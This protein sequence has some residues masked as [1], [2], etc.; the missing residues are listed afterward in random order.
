MDKGMTMAKQMLDLQRVTFDSMI[1]GMLMFWDQ[2]ERMVGPFL[3]QAAWMP[4]EGKKAV[5]DWL[6]TNR[7][8]CESFKNAVDTGYSNLE[9]FF[10][11]TGQQQQEPSRAQPA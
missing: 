3:E 11:G 6:D 9:K 5:R 4:E 1:N 2:T 10:G 8:G 7:R